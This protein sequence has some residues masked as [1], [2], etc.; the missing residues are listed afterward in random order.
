MAEQENKNQIPRSQN[1]E[2]ASDSVQSGLTSKKPQLTIAEIQRIAALPRKKMRVSD[3]IQDVIIDEKTGYVYFPNPKPKNDTDLLLPKRV[4]YTPTEHKEETPEKGEEPE[5]KEARTSLVVTKTSSA[6]E[7]PKRKI[8]M[9]IAVACSIA[10]VAI[11]A[12]SIPVLKDYLPQ[13]ANMSFSSGD[14]VAIGENVSIVQVINN[15]CAFMQQQM[16]L[17]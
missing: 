4:P 1:A 17:H 6:E 3:T 7:K 12:M 15:I 13:G 9:I 11:G 14:E 2:R 10:V 5:D 16:T 8:S